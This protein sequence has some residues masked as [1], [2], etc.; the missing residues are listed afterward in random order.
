MCLTCEFLQKFGHFGISV[1]QRNGILSKNH[2]FLNFWHN[3]ILPCYTHCNFFQN[4]VHIG[5]S[6]KQR[7]GI[8]S[9]NHELLNFWHNNII[10]WDTLKKVWC[11]S[12]CNCP[13]LRDVSGQSR[14]D[15]WTWPL[16]GLYRLCIS[17]KAYH[18]FSVCTMISTR[19]TIHFW[20]SAGMDN[21]CL[22][23]AYST[24]R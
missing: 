5:I 18:S 8:L 19:L 9:K 7:N 23:L 6:V 22:H 21:L 10:I 11:V 20:N 13:P 16:R 4:Y 1:K 15:P 3:S 12:H 17:L 24:V 2:E 14:L